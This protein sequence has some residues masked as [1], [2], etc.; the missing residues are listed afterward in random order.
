M[1]K[2]VRKVKAT[3]GKLIPDAVYARLAN[4]IS[5]AKNYSYKMN[6][7]EGDLFEITD[8]R[9]K[10]YISQRIRHT[11]YKKGIDFR[12][13]LLAGDYF[14]NQLE[15]TPGGVFIDCGANVGELGIWARSQQLEYHAFEPEEREARCCDLNNY[16]GE[17]LTNRMGLWNETGELKF[18]S[19]P[20]SAD[21]SLIEISGFSEIKTVSVITLDDYV[22]QRGISAI[23]L[24]KVEAEGAEPE[25]LQGARNSLSVCRYVTV[26]CGPERGLTSENTV[27]EVTNYLYGMGFRIAQFE[28]TRIIILFEQAA[29]SARLAA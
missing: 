20:S 14:I 23:E 3:L 28:A 29:A 13:N 2:Q 7:A 21:S 24:L 9:K 27:R 25:V 12:A 11:R 5:A 26:D 16:Q 18:Y 4:T 8:P 1:R 15:L 10:I 6:L 19:K 17:R 22:Q